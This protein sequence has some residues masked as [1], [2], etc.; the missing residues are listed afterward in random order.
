MLKSDADYGYDPISV[1]VFSS[2]GMARAIMILLG[3]GTIGAF[4]AASAQFGLFGQAAL[5][6]EA[7]RMLGLPVLAGMFI[8]LGLFPHQ[9]PGLWELLIFHK[10][11][12]PL[13]LIPYLSTNVASAGFPTEETACSI[14]NRNP[15]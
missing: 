15:S 9:M 10:A 8:L 3:L 5:N 6:V 14:M 13:F 12:V 11:G 1:S 4:I 2:G 7:W